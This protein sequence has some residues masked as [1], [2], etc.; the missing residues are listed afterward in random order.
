MKCYYCQQDCEPLE[1]GPKGNHWVCKQHPVKVYHS[2]E[3]HFFYLY[4]YPVITYV[5]PDSNQCIF[6]MRS[7]H[8]DKDQDFRLKFIPNFTPE[9]I[10]AKIET[11]LPFF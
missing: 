4:C 10:H 1:S 6:R 8:P 9:N 2:K 5:Y 3:P 7:G 11:Y